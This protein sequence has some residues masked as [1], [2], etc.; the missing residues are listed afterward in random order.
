MEIE[1]QYHTEDDGFAGAISHSADIIE[2]FPEG[3]EEGTP[4]QEVFAST[5]ADETIE[6]VP[7][8]PALHISSD[9]RMGIHY[10]PDHKHYGQGALQKW[11]PAIQSL[12][13]NWITLPA[14]LDRAIPDEF[15]SGLISSDIQPVLQFDIPLTEEYSV[16]DF[17]AL[18]RAYASWGVRYAVLFDR[19]NLR[20]QWPGVAWTQRGLVD[21]FLDKFIPLAQAARQAG[22]TPVFPALEPGGDYWDT[23]FLRSALEGLQGRGESELLASLVLGTYAW[24]RDRSMTWGAGGPENWPATMP[25][26]TPEGS[27]D[28]MGFRIFDWYNAI[29]RAV[30]GSVL[31]IILVAAGVQRENSQARDAQPVRRAIAMAESLQRAPSDTHNNRVPANVLACNFWLLCAAEDSPSSVHSWFRYQTAKPN[32][33]GEEWLDWNAPKAKSAAAAQPVAAVP[34]ATSSNLF[35]GSKGITK[36]QTL[37]HYMLLPHAEHWPM[38][39]VRSFLESHQAAVGTSL[40]Q[41]LA[42]S[43]VTLA[44]GLE[45]YP[46]E[47]LRTLIQAGCAVDNLQAA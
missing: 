38:D 5:P 22:L 14:P 40:E 12:G 43:R 34:P 9:K 29:S 24:T 35:A 16:E 26:H 25:Y 6:A 13:V 2:D 21:N 10:F 8:E 41:A 39:T 44:G 15:I 42:A 4:F 17:A 20:S 19:P 37:A 11:L 27:E 36:T 30:T 28:Q 1:T 32:Q 3:A 45:A 18:F 33:Q 23:A 46:D 7:V 31:P 47:T